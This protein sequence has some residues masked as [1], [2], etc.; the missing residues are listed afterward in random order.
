MPNVRPC[1]PL[2]IGYDHRVKAGHPR[3][4]GRPGSVAATPAGWCTWHRTAGETLLGTFH[5]D[6]LRPD[7]VD[8]SYGRVLGHPREAHE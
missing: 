1:P 4:N 2:G 8:G 6:D 5:E 3:F 7:T